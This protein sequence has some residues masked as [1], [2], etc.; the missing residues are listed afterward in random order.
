MIRFVGFVAF[1]VFI[2]IFTVNLVYAEEYCEVTRPDGTVDLVECCT[3]GS[4]TSEPSTDYCTEAAEALN[5]KEIDQLE[6]VVHKLKTQRLAKFLRDNPEVPIQKF[7]IEEDSPLVLVPRCCVCPPAGEAVGCA[8][9]CTSPNSDGTC[10][11]GYPF[12]W[13]CNGGCTPID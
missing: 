10:P 2:S 7:T 9:I 13:L 1:F 5:T 11:I 8:I 6:K 12:R 4:S 3:I